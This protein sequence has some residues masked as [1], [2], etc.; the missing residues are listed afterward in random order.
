MTLD[1]IVLAGGRSSRFGSDKI[2]LLLADV[3]AGLPAD[4]A[5]VCVGP[6]RDGPARPDRNPVRW[7]RE[8]PAYG[9]PLAGVAAG[10]AAGTAPV[11]ALVGGDMPRVGRAVVA[12]A[13]AAEAGSAPGAVLVA[14]DGRAQLLASAWRR[15]ALAARLAAIGDPAGKALRL[16]LDG[17][18]L[19]P[20]PDV[21]GAGRDVDSPAD[22]A[23]D[24]DSDGAPAG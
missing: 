14:A 6:R 23:A 12:L 7:V 9:G 8:E 1:V 11:V 22:L 24:G 13:A 18:A 4:A 10:L 16:L 21:W 15:A 3:L 5:V 2:A 19:A 17:E 20:V